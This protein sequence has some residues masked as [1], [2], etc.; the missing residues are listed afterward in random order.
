MYENPSGLGPLP[1]A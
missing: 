1:N